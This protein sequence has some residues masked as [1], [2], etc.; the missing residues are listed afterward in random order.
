[1]KADWHLQVLRGFPETHERRIIEVLPAVRHHVR[2]KVN[3][4]AS[5]LLRANGFFH[6][7]F[8]VDLRKETEVG[9][10]QENL[11][12]GPWLMVAPV[13][14]RR[15]KFMT[16]LK[17]EYGAI[18]VMFSGWAIRPGYVPMVGADHAFPM[19]DHCDYAEL[20]K[21]VDEVSPETVYTTHGFAEEF[22]LDLRKR[23]YDAKPLEGYQSSLS[24]Y[25]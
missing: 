15:N 16:R 23:G 9:G 13:M 3:A 1:M 19:S 7:A 14:N 8:G 22:A 20:L 24:D 11:P 10:E 5:F 4:G 6:R 2:R 18:S 21:L 12:N 17:K 25:R